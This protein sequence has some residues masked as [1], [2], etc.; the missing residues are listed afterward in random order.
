LAKARDTLRFHAEFM[1]LIYSGLS[2]TVYSTIDFVSMCTVAAKANKTLVLASV[3]PTDET[4]NW[5]IAYTKFKREPVNIKK[6]SNRNQRR[7][8]Q[9][10]EEDLLDEIPIDQK[11]S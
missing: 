5:I 3:I 6:T 2:H 4:E 11:R 8:G 7:G 9:Q 10:T 1:V